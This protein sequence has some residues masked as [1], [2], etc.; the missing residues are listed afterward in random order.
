VN[1]SKPL[2]LHVYDDILQKIT[3]GYYA[4][5]DIL[6]SEPILQEQYGVSRIT[7]RRAME[8][9][10]RDGYIGKFPGLGTIVKSRKR[11]VNLKKL[12]SFTEE[13]DTVNRNTNS[14]LIDFKVMR[15]TN[16][17]RVKLN[18]NEDDMVYKIDRVRIINDIPVGF[19][20]SFIPTSIIKLSEQDFSGYSVSLYQKLRDN[21]VILYDAEESIE[22][23]AAT[24][25]IQ[26]HL[27]V[28]NSFPI[29][30]KERTT[31]DDNRVAIEFVEIYYN[32]NYYKYEIQ[33]S[34]I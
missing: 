23:I 10:Q 25:E 22:A 2:Y 18:L 24:P 33:L 6:P 30:Y 3:E 20:R 13:N 31:F 12:G 8:D 9:L 17:V 27:N 28:E 1:K 7:V 5:N 15:P 16:K 14:R 19:H 34:N 4:E 29:L 32:S 11:I 21:G 26:K